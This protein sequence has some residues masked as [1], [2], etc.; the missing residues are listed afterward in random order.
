MALVFISL[1]KILHPNK[2][3][4]DNKDLFLQYCHFNTQAKRSK[5]FFLDCFT[6]VIPCTSLPWSQCHLHISPKV[7]SF[8]EADKKN[9]VIFLGMRNGERPNSWI[10]Y[11]NCSNQ[12]LGDCFNS[13]EDFFNFHTFL[14]YPL[15]TNSDGCSIYISSIRI[16]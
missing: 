7:F 16:P 9:W 4:S 13:Y 15:A 11:A 12:A 1:S 8:C 5:V 14:D 3:A 10:T 2:P 6:S